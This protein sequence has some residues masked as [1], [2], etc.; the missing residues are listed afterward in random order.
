MIYP[1]CPQFLAQAW[2][3]LDIH[4]DLYNR[5]LSECVCQ[6]LA[7]CSWVWIEYYDLFKV[8]MVVCGYQLHRWY[9]YWKGKKAISNTVSIGYTFWDLCLLDPLPPVLL[10][11]KIR[12]PQWHNPVCNLP[13]WGNLFQRLSNFKLSSRVRICTWLQTKVSNVGYLNY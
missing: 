9:L 13:E 10:N 8:C 4:K 1:L 6:L 2:H 12:K 5:W 11:P 7:S 3:V